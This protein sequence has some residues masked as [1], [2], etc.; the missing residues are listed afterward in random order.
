MPILERITS[1]QNA[2]LKLVKS[3]QEKKHRQRERL[4]VVDD[5]RDLQ[6]ALTRGY[7]VAFLLACPALLRPE[8]RDFLDESHANAYELSPDLME[9]VGYRQNPNG[10]I[11][12]LE[13]PPAPALPA[14]LNA[15]VLCLV[16]LEKPGNI[17]A[18][19][20]TADASGFRYVVLVDTAL[21]LYNPNVIRASTGAC[22]LGNVYSLNS[23]QTLEAL[24][25]NRYR[26]LSAHLDGTKSLYDVRFTPQTAV[27]L[28]T[29]DKGLPDL[30][31]Q[32]C[33]EL[34][35]IP[36]IGQLSDSLNV[37]VSGAVFMYEALRQMSKA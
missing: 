6:R 14:S 36:M 31:A 17:G 11:A 30:W 4:F 5:L 32:A 15:P 37:S 22:F 33:D 9:K 12:V 24:R 29:E 18:L 1:P 16:A 7:R 26:I 27:V 21:D 13:Q 35:K 20:R 8:E 23:T 25:A 19:L 34:V 28:G 2:K 3:L 10:L